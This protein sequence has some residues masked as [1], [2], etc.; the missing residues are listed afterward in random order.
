[1]A[2]HA[3]CDFKTRTILMC[4][5]SSLTGCSLH[6]YVK[7]CV[8]TGQ[9]NIQLLGKYNFMFFHQF[10]L[11]WFGFCLL[12]RS[13]GLHQVWAKWWRIS[14]EFKHSFQLLYCCGAQH[15]YQHKLLV[16]CT[17]VRHVVHYR[18]YH[19][20]LLHIDCT[21]QGQLQHS[22]RTWLHCTPK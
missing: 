17:H 14:L 16:Y 19:I 20:L 10:F 18:T 4:M 13:N 2:A 12:W 3:F 11:V 5:V 6:G 8:L 1:M 21:I 7:S 9:S 15:T 22:L